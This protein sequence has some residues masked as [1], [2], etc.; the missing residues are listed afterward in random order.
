MIK[1]AVIGANGRMGSTVVEAITAAHDMECVAQLDAD[2]PITADTLGGASV[3]VD[4][5]I[6]SVTEGNVHTL[7]DVKF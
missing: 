5:T 2:T 1:V 3:A 6:P 4:F 7:L